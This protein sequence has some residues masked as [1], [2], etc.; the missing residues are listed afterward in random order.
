MSKEKAKKHY[1]N[2]NSDILT[3]DSIDDGTKLV[4]AE[5][6][7]LSQLKGFCYASNRYFANKFSKSISTINRR[8]SKLE[9]AGYIKR[10]SIK[11]ENNVVV[12]RR[13]YVTNQETDPHSICD[14]THSRYDMPPS[15]ICNDPH[16]ICDM[17]PHSRYDIPPIADMH[18]GIIQS[19]TTISNN[20]VNTIDKERSFPDEQPYKEIIDYLNERCGT[21]YKPTTK[22]TRK[23]ING[24]LNEG[25][26]IEDFRTVI[27]KKANEWIGTDFEKHLNP[28]TLFRPSNFE[29]Y[30]NQ[31]IIKPKE[32]ESKKEK[33]YFEE[34]MEIEI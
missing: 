16:S 10:D 30:L 14:M 26:T 15:H 31:V 23:N 21:N 6:I 3:D 4:Y 19:N 22:E 20:T 28:T 11:N 9:K 2:I 18:K 32:K 24:R 5:I 25:H 12:E 33:S 27:D 29:K 13:I 7:A 1:L 34:I 8:L 17:T